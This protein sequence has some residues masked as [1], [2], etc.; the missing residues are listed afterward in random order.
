VS[1]GDAAQLSGPELRK[2]LGTLLGDRDR[3]GR[4]AAL[5]RELVDGAGAARAAAEVVAA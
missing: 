2:T 5:G 1:L 3:R 4:M